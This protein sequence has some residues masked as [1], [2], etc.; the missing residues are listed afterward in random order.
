MGWGANGFAKFER[1]TRGC[2]PFGLFFQD[3]GFQPQMGSGP[4]PV[5]PSPTPPSPEPTPSPTPAPT[6]HHAK[7]MKCTPQW[8]ISTKCANRCAVH[9]VH[10]FLALLNQCVNMEPVPW[11][12]PVMMSAQV[13]QFALEHTDAGTLGRSQLCDVA[14]CNRCQNLGDF[15]HVS[16]PLMLSVSTFLLIV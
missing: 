4:S 3:A 5:P 13:A 7:L 6:G 15:W 8:M 1:T 9:L 2:G 16:F 11:F 10:H 14:F 12:A